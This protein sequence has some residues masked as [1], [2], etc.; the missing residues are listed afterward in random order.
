MKYKYSY[1][2]GDIIPI[3]KALIPLTDLGF[4]RG[5]SVFD[6]FKIV[7]GKPLYLE[8]HLM[9]LSHSAGVMNLSLPF[10]IDEIKD[11]LLNFISVNE[12]IKGGIRIMLTG[13]FSDDGFSGRSPNLFITAV[14][15]PVYSDEMY[16][17][18]VKL[19]TLDHQREFSNIKTTNYAMAA[20]LEEKMES[21]GAMDVLYF[22]NGYFSES[23]RSN[24]YIVHQSGAIQTSDTDILKGITR[25]HLLLL[26]EQEF[27]IVLSPIPVSS[28]STAKEAFITSTTKDVMAVNFIDNIMIG[29]GSCGKVT[30]RLME[31][32]SRS[33]D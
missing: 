1:I 9:R 8:D 32:L 31:L 26:A 5:Q 10:E 16:S 7:D 33:R 30:A 20:S 13:G 15:L 19:I 25:H 14:D 18:G 23:S 11:H 24:F 29:D 2:N 21:E 28:I 6:F 4:L 22:N 12:I 3:E 17:K 27:E